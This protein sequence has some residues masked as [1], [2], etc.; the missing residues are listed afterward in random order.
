MNGDHK[1]TQSN[2]VEA[3]AASLLQSVDGRPRTQARQRGRGGPVRLLQ[4]GLLLTLTNWH[5]Q[6]S[7][8]ALSASWH[9]TR[10]DADTS[11]VRLGS[12]ALVRRT[13]AIRPGQERG[14]PKRTSAFGNSVQPREWP[15][16]A[17][18]GLQEDPWLTSAPGAELPFDRAGWSVRC[19]PQ[20][21]PKLSLQPPG[22]DRRSVKVREGRSGLSGN[23]RDRGTTEQSRGGPPVGVGALSACGKGKGA[24]IRNGRRRAPY[25]LGEAA[26]SPV[27]DRPHLRPKS[28][29]ATRVRW[30]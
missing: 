5:G 1:Q 26:S 8:A 15:G 16:W 25:E 18:S 4:G 10:L 9:Q 17:R 19:H 6:R 7:S 20:G 28:P 22:V 3:V 21:R 29:S 12:E 23:R 13:G 2:P 30:V 24:G 11:G 27:V 14:G